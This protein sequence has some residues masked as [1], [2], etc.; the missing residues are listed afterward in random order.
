MAR[1]VARGLAHVHGAAIAALQGHGNPAL[2][3]QRLAQRVSAVVGAGTIDPWR[4]KRRRAAQD[5]RLD[6]ADAP[7]A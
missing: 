7:R 2:G 6:T 1:L 5:G 3:G 4:T